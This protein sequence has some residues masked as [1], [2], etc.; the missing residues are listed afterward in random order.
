MKTMKGSK[1]TVLGEELRL[2]DKAPEFKL[3]K[4]DLTDVTLTDFKEENLLISVVPSLDT[5]VCDLQTRTIYEEL[6]SN[7]NVR[8]ITVSMDLPFAQARWCG[9]AGIDATTLS[10][11]KTGQFGKDYGLLIQE[12]RLLGRAVLV[13]NKKR[14][15][16]YVEY[17]KEMGNHP[18][19][20]AL[21]DFVKGL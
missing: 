4:N 14:E 13:L 12:L 8:F 2:G 20:D 5:S 16:I 11:H 3:T 10:D 1:I 17:L 15:V 19:Y 6:A 9:S 18:N 21:I 7:P